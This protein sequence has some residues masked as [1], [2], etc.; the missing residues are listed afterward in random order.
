MTSGCQAGVLIPDAI[1][2]LA[3]VVYIRHND[4]AAVAGSQAVL[5]GRLGETSEWQR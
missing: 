3:L 5:R 1:A 2:P 4:A